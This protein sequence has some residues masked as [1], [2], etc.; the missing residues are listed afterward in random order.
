MGNRF[1]G[2]ER[3]PDTLTPLSAPQEQNNIQ[4][5]WGRLYSLLNGFK[6]VGKCV[7]L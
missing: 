3:L 5:P 4:L 1:G 2:S 6:S 7:L